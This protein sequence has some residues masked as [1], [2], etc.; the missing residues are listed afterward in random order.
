[1]VPNIHQSL[2]EL[3]EKSK[4]NNALT[5]VNTVYDFLNE[6]K[7]PNAAWPLGSSLQTYQY[8]DLL[9]TDREE[10]LRLSGKET[11]DDALSFFQQ[12]GVGEL[13][14]QM[15]LIPFIMLTIAPYLAHQKVKSRYLKK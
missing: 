5:I 14:L 10:A 7:N 2:T 3:L 9:I 4:E 12:T 13:L 11:V 6:K 15:V 8:I 1:L